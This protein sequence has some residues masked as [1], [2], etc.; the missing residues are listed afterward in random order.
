[1]I[2]HMILARWNRKAARMPNPC[3]TEVEKAWNSRGKIWRTECKG[4]W[5]PI[6]IYSCLGVRSIHKGNGQAVRVE[7]LAARSMNR[8]NRA[9]CWL[10]TTSKLRLTWFSRSRFLGRAWNQMALALPW[11]KALI[12]SSCCPFQRFSSHRCS[13]K[14]VS[15]SQIQSKADNH[16]SS[17]KV[18][19]KEWMN[20]TPMTVSQQA[21]LQRAI[22]RN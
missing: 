1:M 21:S 9:S 16:S 3:N 2:I 19:G 14:K 15:S 7:I 6:E 5:A 10:E 17:R 11:C 13:W 20:L 4:I 18:L 22:S 8:Y 12:P